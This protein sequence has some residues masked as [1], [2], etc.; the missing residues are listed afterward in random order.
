M[1]PACIVTLHDH[2][3]ANTQ[4]KGKYIHKK[5]SFNIIECLVCSC[6]NTLADIS[7]F[8]HTYYFVSVKF[9]MHYVKVTRH[10]I[11]AYYRFCDSDAHQ[12]GNTNK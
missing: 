8:S 6:L 11:I 5:A 3:F 12:H 10:T 9:M 4:N 7:D 1:V 2:V